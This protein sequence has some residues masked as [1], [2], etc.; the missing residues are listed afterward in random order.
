M[1]HGILNEVYYPRVDQANMRDMGLMI[2]DGADL[3]SEE[4][5]H[6]KS[7]VSLLAPGTPGYRLTNTCV[8]GRYRIVK[9]IIGDPEGDVLLQEIRFEALRGARTDYRLYVNFAPHLG[10]QDAD[11]S[12][13]VGDYKGVPMLF[14]EPGSRAFALACSANFAAASCG[15]V[16]V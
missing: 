14:A 7:T 9:T 11:N 5:R 1:S 13:W 10:N 3:F 6:T 15:Y 4:K 16:G 2:T 12:G 8:E